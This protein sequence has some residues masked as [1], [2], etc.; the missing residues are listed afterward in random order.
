MALIGFTFGG[1]GTLKGESAIF[2]E[3]RRRGLKVAVAGIPKTINNA[4]QYFSF[5]V[6]DKSFGFDTA[7][8][9]ANK[10]LMQHTLKE[11]ALIIELLLSRLIAMYA[12]LSSRDVDCCLIPESQFY[13]EGPGGHMVIVIAEGA[14]QCMRTMDQQDASGN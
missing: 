12:T 2:K 10:L 13:L 14:R 5:H 4:F 7:V 11:K 3:I 1:D 9:E 8:K 6:I